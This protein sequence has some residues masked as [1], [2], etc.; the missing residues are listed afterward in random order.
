M[1]MMMAFTEQSACNF[2][3]AI[4]LK[5]QS[6]IKFGMIQIHGTVFITSTIPS[7]T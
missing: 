5:A 7:Q 6:M 2:Q 4:V 3:Q 1:M